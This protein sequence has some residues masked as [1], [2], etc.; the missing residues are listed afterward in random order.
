MRAKL[1]IIVA[2]AALLLGPA[3]GLAQSADDDG[4]I[5]TAPEAPRS[6]EQPPPDRPDAPPPT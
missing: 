2:G 6:A 1:T 3:A 4:P 5:A